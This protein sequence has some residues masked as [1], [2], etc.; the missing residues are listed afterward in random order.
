MYKLLTSSKDSNDLSIGFDRCRDRRKQ[1]FTNNKNVKGKYHVRIYLR[2]FLGFAE[3][4]E[5]AIY[6]LSYKLTL[7]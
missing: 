2:V 7:T 1:E 4:Q 5:T 6:G 3:H